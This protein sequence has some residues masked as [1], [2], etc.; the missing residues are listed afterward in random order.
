MW[1][2]SARATNVTIR[3]CPLAKFL[4]LFTS[5]SNAEHAAFTFAESRQ[6]LVDRHT[7]QPILAIPLRLLLPLCHAVRLP[8][9]GKPRTS[10][11]T[12]SFLRT[13]SIVYLQPWRC[14]RI[15][16]N[17]PGIPLLD[18]AVSSRTGIATNWAAANPSG[19]QYMLTPLVCIYLI[20][21]TTSY[22]EKRVRRYSHWLCQSIGKI[23]CESRWRLPCRCGAAVGSKPVAMTVRGSR[24]IHE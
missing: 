4:G 22:P 21:C 13:I 3:L 1:K 15:A 20:P 8:A 14:S 12:Y 9:E 6:S 18:F 24:W 17:H 2:Y 16:D 5:R 7:M 23:P 19:R 11:G 10:E